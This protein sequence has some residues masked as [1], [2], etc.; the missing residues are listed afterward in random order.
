MKGL[1][2]YKDDVSKTISILDNELGVINNHIQQR[3]HPLASVLARVNQEPLRI[4]VNPMTRRTLGSLEQRAEQSRVEHLQVEQRAEP[5]VEQR[6]EHVQVEQRAGPPVEQR[7][8]HVQVEQRVDPPVE[9]R[10]EPQVGLPQ[11]EQRTERA[12]VERE[13]GSPIVP[14]T[15]FDPD[16]AIRRSLRS[17]IPM[18]PIGMA[19][20]GLT[21]NDYA[22]Y[23][24]ERGV[25]SG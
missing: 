7:V 14:L 6:V 1:Q 16:E 12:E 15:H 24:L 18:E 3:Q 20:G 19:L 2:S 21:D 13:N 5:P 9:Q 23:L 22:K 17:Q 11:V 4:I 25:Q 8:E 10:I